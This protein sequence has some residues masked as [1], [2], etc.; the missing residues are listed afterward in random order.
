MAR[1]LA[2]WGD[3]TNGQLGDGASAHRWAPQEL[4][5][6]ENIATMDAGSGHAFALGIDGDLWGW[7]RNAFGQLADGT[8]ENQNA[9]VRATGL[10]GCVLKVGAGGGH[11]A[12][13]LDDGTVWAWGAGFFCALG[14][15]EFGVQMQPLLVRGLEDVVDLAVGGAHNLALK[16]DGSVWSWG[17]DDR[18]QLGDGP[19]SEREGRIVRSYMSASF[20]C[21]PRPARVE[22]LEPA[23]AVAAGGGHSMVVHA[24]GSLSAWG[25]NDRGQLGDGTFEDRPAPQ[26]VRGIPGVARISGGYHHTVALMVDGTVWAWG[27]NDGG[28]LGDG[29]TQDRAEP[30]AVSGLSGVK[31]VSA[32]GGGTDAAPGNGGHNLALR[33]DGTVYGWGWNNYGQLAADPATANVL[34]PRRLPLDRPALDVTAGGEIP[35]SNKFMANPGG[36]FGLALLG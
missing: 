13:L 1:T 36:G 26:K 4:K 31:S 23:V 11:T 3:N 12:A 14:E 9:P 30:R 29:T 27:L 10:P 7:G 28:Q 15:D 21:R 6:P 8:T 19:G 35:V 22:G 5:G 18:G 32:H 33:S 24:D 16:A 20:D 2:S 34:T 17:R 25:F